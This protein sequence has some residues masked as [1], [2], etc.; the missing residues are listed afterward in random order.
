[1][2]R[3]NADIDQLLLADFKG[4]ATAGGSYS[5]SPE[6]LDYLVNATATR[7][8]K[9]KQRGGSR[10]ISIS[11]STFPPEAFQF[12]FAGEQFYILRSGTD[13][14]L[15]R[16]FV[17]AVDQEVYTLER[18]ADKLNVLRPA[19]ANEPATY[20]VRTEGEYCHVLIATASSTLIDI[21]FVYRDVVIGSITPTTAVAPFPQRYSVSQSNTKVVVD[22]SITQTSATTAIANTNPQGTDITFTWVTRPASVVV[23]RKLRVFSAFWMR[24]IDANY[25]R[26]QDLANTG[27]RRN[28]VALDVNMP[29]PEPLT[30]NYIYN[31]PIQDLSIESYK[32]Y[33]STLAGAS[34]LTRTTNKQPTTSTT[35][36][37]SDG[38]YKPNNSQT[39]TATSNYIAFGALETGNTVSK[40]TIVRLRHIL[41]GGFSSIAPVELFFSIDTTYSNAISMHTAD[42]SIAPSPFSLIRYFSTAATNTTSPGIG[43]DSLVEVFLAYDA[44]GTGNFIVANISNSREF[45]EIGDGYCFPLYGYSLIARYKSFSFP[46][47][48]RFVGN[49]LVLSGGNRILCSSSDWNYRGISFNNC[50][51]STLNFDENSPFIVELEQAGGKVNNIESSNGIFVVAAE[52]STY[53]ISG[54]TYNSPPNATTAQVSR[55]T[56]QTTNS[57]GLAVF[58]NQVYMANSRGFFRIAYDRAT[59]SSQLEELSLPVSDL[60]TAQPDAITYSRTLQSVVI[61]LK[62]SNKL[63]RYD[64]LSKTWSYLHIAVPLNV[65]LFSTVDGF[66]LTDGFNIIA[67]VWSNVV[68]SDLTNIDILTSFTIASNSVQIPPSGTS[69]IALATP[70]ELQQKYSTNSSILPAYGRFK[71]RTGDN[72]TAF[73]NETTAGNVPKPVLSYAVTKALYSSKL[74]TASRLRSTT[75]LLSGVGSA[76][77]AVHEVNNDT[78]SSP[79]SFI[80]DISVSATGAITVSGSYTQ[81]STLPTYPTSETVAVRLSNLGISEAF[82]VALLFSGVEVVGLELSSTAK[83]TSRLS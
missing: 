63:L 13:F 52:T 57:K 14:Y 50:Q 30:K 4:M 35:W 27:L 29:V 42:G 2:A 25:Y 40:P 80:S 54:S 47:I 39:T 11:S 31:E 38:S 67:G 19:S 15:F 71:A 74:V 59:D 62:G 79:S 82:K 6:Y 18:L 46:N 21:C 75:V 17:E 8:G 56:N 73:V 34:S 65:I 36:D 26:G 12:A 61:K 33:L 81:Q 9:L 7:E 83:G 53:R 22:N 58:D 3:A 37:F 20:A 5:A 10:L 41:V 45:V 49:R 1:M 16:V 51:V 32:V 64:L 43:L 66:Y 76:S 68:T 24:A 44:S 55:V 28:T 70:P 72:T 23:G 77:V 69:T 78:S 48:V 60:F